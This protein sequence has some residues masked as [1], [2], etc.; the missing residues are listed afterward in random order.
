MSFFVSTLTCTA[1][2]SVSRSGLARSYGNCVFNIFE[3]LPDFVAALK[4]C[5][6]G[7]AFLGGLTSNLISLFEI[8]TVFASLGTSPPC[9]GLA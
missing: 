5:C 4:L 8:L 1:F 7:S 6:T 9:P 3:K 2:G